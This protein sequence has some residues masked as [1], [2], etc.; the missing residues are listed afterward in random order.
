[1]IIFGFMKKK[2][3]IKRGRKPVDDKKVHLPL[4]VPKS[5][6]DLLGREKA[7]EAGYKGIKQ[8]IAELNT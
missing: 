2:Q 6:I 5:T 1:V 7:I 4:Y 8:Q 3:K